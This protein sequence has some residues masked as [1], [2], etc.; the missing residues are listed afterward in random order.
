MKDSIIKSE[1]IGW[2]AENEWQP[3]KTS[4]KD[5][6]E[7]LI[8]KRVD[9]RTLVQQVFWTEECD[10]YRPLIFALHNATHWMPVPEIPK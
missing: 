8:G 3:I 7:I 6:R 1:Q 9:G 10:R 2:L 4:P 5:G